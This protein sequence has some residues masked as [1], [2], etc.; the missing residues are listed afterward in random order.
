[1]PTYDIYLQ[2]KTEEHLT[3]FASLTFGFTRTVAVRGP[4]KLAV[5]WLKRFLTQKGSDPLRPDD[6]TNFPSLIGSNISSMA[7]IRDVLLLAIQ[8]CNEQIFNLQSQAPP[9]L[10]E[11]LLNATLDRFETNTADGFDAW[12]ALSNAAG[13]TMTIRLQ[14]FA[15]TA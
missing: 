1:M 9:D 11:Q 4:Y 15:N 7:D 2:G 13:Q 12:V 3:G 5:Q 8:D 10:D 6:G 14:D